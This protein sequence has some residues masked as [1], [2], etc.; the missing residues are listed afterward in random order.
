MYNKKIM[1]KLLTILTIQYRESGFQ[2]KKLEYLDLVDDLGM[3]SITFIS[4]VIE[5]E[6]Q[7]SIKI[8][9]NELLI[10]NFKT[11]DNIYHIIEKC[12]GTKDKK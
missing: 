3:D 7:F 11:I 10:E 2:F 5:I 9:E 8:P 1:D 4:I 6:E 12:V